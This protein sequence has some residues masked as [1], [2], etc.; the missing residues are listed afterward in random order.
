M[1]SGCYGE[2]ISQYLIS[3]KVL[4]L[5]GREIEIKKNQIDFFIEVQVYQKI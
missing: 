5:N 1:N 3:I 4:D 2:E